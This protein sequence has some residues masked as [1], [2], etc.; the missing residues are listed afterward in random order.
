M[1]Q[2][3]LW[4]PVAVLIAILLVGGGAVVAK[5]IIEALTPVEYEIHWT[6]SVPVLVALFACGLNW[7]W[8]KR[9]GQ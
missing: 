6:T 4:T 5:G 2:F 9:R 8:N 3:T 1:F 7:E